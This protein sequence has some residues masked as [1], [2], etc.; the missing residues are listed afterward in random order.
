[1]ERDLFCE[2]NSMRKTKTINADKT[3]GE[4]EDIPNY[5]KKKHIR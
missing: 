2:I 3:D 5:L 1:M 4:S